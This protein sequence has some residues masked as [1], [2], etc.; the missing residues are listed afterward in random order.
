MTCAPNQ[1]TKSNTVSV[2][3]AVLLGACSLAAAGTDLQLRGKYGACQNNQKMGLWDLSGNS[4]LIRDDMLRSNFCWLTVPGIRVQVIAKV[5]KFARVVNT[6]GSQEYMV[7]QADL[8]TVTAAKEIV[9]D[10]TDKASTKIQS[11]SV[12]NTIERG[13]VYDINGDPTVQV[14]IQVDKKL[15]LYFSIVKRLVA[16]GY[17]ITIDNQKSPAM[18]VG[19]KCDGAVVGVGK[20]DFYRIQILSIDPGSKKAVLKMSGKMKKCSLDSPHGYEISDAEIIL[21]GKNFTEFVRPHT[22]AELSKR[23][24]PFKW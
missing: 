14:N 22:K 9:R 6:S 19:G 3:G 2:L 4:P 5:G 15:S 21:T 13:E 23:F 1:L 18:Q 12:R 8:E 7:Y 20:P 16:E 24:V 11:V 10:T 17:D